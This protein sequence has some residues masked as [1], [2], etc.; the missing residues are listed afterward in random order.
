MARRR[1][2]ALPP[3]ARRSAIGGGSVSVSAARAAGPAPSSRSSAPRRAAPLG[4]GRSGSGAE[5]VAL[6]RAGTSRRRR[7]VP[8]AGTWKAYG[9]AGV[10][11]RAGRV[12]ARGPGP[13]PA[14]S[15]HSSRRGFTV[16]TA[17][18]DASTPTSPTRFRSPPSSSTGEAAVAE[19]WREPRA[20]CGAGERSSG[21]RG[22]V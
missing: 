21:A 16:S 4:P 11:P 5:R 14:P 3:P 20:L 1:D 12:Q 6:S 19:A 2:A 8:A 15:H 10:L 7:A 17:S 9:L 22:L 13:G 18:A